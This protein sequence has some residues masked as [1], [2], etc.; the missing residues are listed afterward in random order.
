M[1]A[2]NKRDDADTGVLRIRRQIGATRRHV[3]DASH[4]VAGEPARRAVERQEGGRPFT[5]NAPQNRAITP[6]G[7]DATYEERWRTIQRVE[8]EEGGSP[9]A[10]QHAAQRRQEHGH[11]ASRSQTQRSRRRHAKVQSEVASSFFLSSLRG[12]VVIYAAASD[13]PCARSHIP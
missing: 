11:R 3:D 4:G 9:G 2:E 10:R 1:S 5:I 13:W 6:R 8:R 12:D 7:F